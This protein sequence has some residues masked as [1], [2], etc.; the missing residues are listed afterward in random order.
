M[1]TTYTKTVAIGLLCLGFLMGGCSSFEEINRPIGS[2]SSEELKTD[3]LSGQNALKVMF[4]ISFPQQEND[5]QMTYDL[6]GNIYGRYFAETKD[7]WNNAKTSTYNAPGG[8]INYPYSNIWPRLS[9]VMQDVIDEAGEESPVYYWALILR[10]HALLNLTDTYGPFPFG[11]TE[12][13]AFAPQSE[14]Y[15]AIL[16]DL[17]AATE[18]FSKALVADPSFTLFPQ[19]DV[20]YG[21]EIRRWVLFAN[22]LK[23]RMA[24]RMSLVE[25]DLARTIGEKAILDGVIEAN[26][27]NLT[28][29]YKPA[30][31]YK[32]SVEWGDAVMSAE[33]DSYLS[34]YHD[35]RAEKYFAP[36]KT[37]AD[38]TRVGLQAGAFIGVKAK[39]LELYSQAIWPEDKPSIWMTAAEVAFLRAEGDLRGWNVGGSAQEWYEKGVRLS[40]QQW[41]ADQADLYLANHSDKPMPYINVPDGYGRNSAPLSNLTVAWDDAA[42][43]EQK[44][45]RLMIQKW[46]ALYPLG[47]EAWADIRRTGYPNIYPPVQATPGYANL[48]TAN[49]IPYPTSEATKDPKNFSLMES[50]LG[51]KNDYATKMWWQ[52]K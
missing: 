28:Y 24:I 9:R 13:G 22:S 18:Y 31:I 46:I 30:G 23:L 1:S 47:S 12:S 43:F 17:D 3:N 40:F 15:K 19:A 7:A 48:K 26:R 52:K 51:G 42:P 14:V 4:N 49:R 5:F 2:V 16:K 45:E 44:L 35:P 36:A 50:Q 41:G 27:D 21:G 11:G 8:W 25:P 29:Q 20:I 39:A 37:P 38:R 34:G 10:A 33:M 32:T 6:I